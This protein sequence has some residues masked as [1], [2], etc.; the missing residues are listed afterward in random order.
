M[1]PLAVSRFACLWAG[2]A[3]LLAAGR[4]AAQ[5][6]SMDQ[7]VRAA[8]L[9]CFPL[10]NNPREYVYLPARGRLGEDE[11]GLPQF[12]L[13]K[14][15]VN[16]NRADS[17]NSITAASGGG[18]LTLQLYYDTP[19][20][21]ISA[22]EKALREIRRDDAVQ[23][24]GPIVFA[25]GTYALVSSILS[26]GDKPERKLLLTGRAPVLEGNRL[27]LS[28]NLSPQEASLL[29]QSLQ[30][31]TPDVSLVF[32]L[33]FAGLSD[34]YD[35]KLTVDWSE[36]RKSKAFRAGGSVY[37]VS[38]EVQA[39]FDD[40]LR[41]NAI[42]LQ[43]SGADAASE[44]L[45]NTVYARLLDLLFRPVEPDKLPPGASGGVARAM[46]ALLDPST[47]ILGSG[48]TMGF[49]LHAG[50]QLKEM[51]SEGTSYLTFNHR[52]NV[53]R[54]SFVTFNIGNVYQRWGSDARF[55]RTA[56]LEDPAFLQREVKVVLDGSLLGEFDRFVNYVSVM[57]KKR[58]EDGSETV[59][60]LVMSKA[61]LTN[62]APV[63]VYGWSGDQDRVAW[64]GYDYKATWSFRGG[65]S[66]S[67]PL[68]HTSDSVLNLFAPY[69]RRTVQ[70]SA[71][72]P[73][74]A[75]RAVKAATVE[76]A[77][78]FFGQPKVSRVVWRP[79]ENLADKNIE[80]T[81]PSGVFD[82]DYTVTWLLENDRRL[83]K[84]SRDSSGVIFLDDFGGAADP[85]ASDTTKTSATG[86]Q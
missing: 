2:L 18:I 53:S 17:A 20:E 54:H 57:L 71:D 62:A 10:V 77:Y 76:V 38:A 34:A 58:H 85:A 61:A 26:G 50:F 51:R 22:A 73:A 66:Y 23:V 28:F 68:A 78:R 32:D 33:E 13:L 24:R 30:S 31:S 36:V 84:R 81:Q 60:D 19:P 47:G 64:L 46:D 44:A 4:A 43:T 83:V 39:A 3:L 12:S 41:N 82:Y 9:W 55:F 69:E 59:R 80:L 21:L 79:S 7:G 75:A 1:S 72:L 16:T 67:T 11:K 5:S 52:Q 35:A 6:I 25:S 42:H 29:S 37:F 74:L 27:A 40:L 70:L 86:V 14:Y 65:G 48:K 15:V 8:G 49:G 45:L 56:N 63:L